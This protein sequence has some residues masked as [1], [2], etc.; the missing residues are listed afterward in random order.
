MPRPFFNPTT[1]LSSSENPPWGLLRKRRTEG[2]EEEAEA[3]PMPPAPRTS[4]APAPR[5]SR[6]TCWSS[7]AAAVV[8][9]HSSSRIVRRAGAPCRGLPMLL[10]AGLATRSGSRSGEAGRGLP[11]LLLL[12]LPLLLLPPL[13]VVMS[14]TGVSGA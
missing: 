4:S 7:G 2:E 9:S 10:G 3:P 13:V 12:L 11:L 14:L 1:P 8:W 6:T 5:Y